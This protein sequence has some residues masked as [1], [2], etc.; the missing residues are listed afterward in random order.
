MYSCYISL[1][2]FI[3]KH[4]P[5]NTIS[6]ST[7]MQNDLLRLW[8]KLNNNTESASDTNMVNGESDDMKYER[9]LHINIPVAH[10]SFDKN[11]AYSSHASKQP[12][13]SRFSCLDISNSD[14]DNWKC[15]KWQGYRCVLKH[16]ESHMFV[17]SYVVCI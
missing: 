13:C 11:K 10:I 4:T 5:I 7:G 1:F 14:R 15:S 17:H 6:L 2:T 3:Y 8:L 9:I 16:P 12:T